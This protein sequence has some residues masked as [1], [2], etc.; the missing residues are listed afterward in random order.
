MK[1]RVAFVLLLLVSF[2]AAAGATAG[3]RAGGRALDLHVKIEDPLLAYVEGPLSDA[4]R[5]RCPHTE[6]NFSVSIPHATLYL[7]D[8]VDVAGAVRAVDGLYATLPRG[9]EFSMG[10]PVL[11]G[12]YFMW[13]AIVTPCLQLLSDSV[14]NATYAFHDPDMPIPAWVLNATEPARSEMIALF[15]KYGSPGVF[16]MFT[17]QCVCC[18]S[19][20]FFG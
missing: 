16:S 17:A 4:V 11:S 2:A 20:F 6:V 5:A 13:N 1:R 3:V 15:K 10:K 9:C 7:T 18:F 19:A 14:V 12:Q 8:F